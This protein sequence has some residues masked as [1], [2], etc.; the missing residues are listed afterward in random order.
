MP[1]GRKRGRP[2]K[3]EE[4]RTNKH[5]K[6]IEERLLLCAKGDHDSTVYIGELVE[7]CLTGEIGAVL[8]ALT[9]G[10]TAIEIQRNRDNKLSAERVLGR[11]EMA[12]LLWNDLEQYVADKDALLQPLK[13]VKPS[14]ETVSEGTPQAA[15]QNFSY[16]T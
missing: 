1:T 5:L 3:G 4:V 9:A 12:D 8:K 16:T 7:R 15:E 2:R 11:I 10:R 13:E 6:T 14:Y